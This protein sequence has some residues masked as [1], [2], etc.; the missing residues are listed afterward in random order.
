[1]KHATNNDHRAHAGGVCP[2]WLWWTDGHRQAS[3]WGS[4]QL[5]RESGFVGWLAAPRYCMPG[6]PARGRLHG[7]ALSPIEMSSVLSARAPERPA[8]QPLETSGDNVLL[9]NLSLLSPLGPQEVC[10]CE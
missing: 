6:V 10:V 8:L 3:E 5:Q 7:L 4:E 2:V 1:M 9:L